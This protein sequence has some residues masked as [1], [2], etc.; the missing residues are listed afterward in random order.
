MYRICFHN[1][2]RHRSKASANVQQCIATTT[3]RYLTSSDNTTTT[4]TGYQSIGSFHS[5]NLET[6]MNQTDDAYTPPNLPFLEKDLKSTITTEFSTHKNQHDGII[7]NSKRNDFMID[8]H[9]WTFLNH[10]AFGG[11]LKVGYIRSEQWRKYIEL[12]PLRYFDRDLLPHLVYS[13]RLLSKFINV[14]H[15]NEIT[16]LVN[17]TAGL[18]ATLSGHV[19]YYGINNVHIILWDTTYGSVKKMAQHYYGNDNISEIPFQQNYLNRIKDYA[20]DPTQLFIEALDECMMKNKNKMNGKKVIFCL[21]HISSNTA[22]TFPIEQLAIQIKT[23]YNYNQYDDA[24]ILVDGA[25]AL[26]TQN[27]NTSDLL[28][29]YGID[30]Y[31]TNLHKWFS[32]PRGIACMIVQSKWHNTILRKPAIISHGIDENDL[33]SRYIWD[34]CRDYTAALSIPTVIN[35]WNSNY[36]NGLD[37]LRNELR[38]KLKEG[39]L[40]LAKHWYP[41]DFTDN[42]STDDEGQMNRLMTTL[43]PFS[44]SSFSSPMCLIALPQVELKT[45]QTSI[46]AKKLQDCL[47]NQHQIEVPIKCIN[48]QLYIRISCHIY[49]TNEDFDKLGK[50]I[51]MI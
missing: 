12:Q 1:L 36:P 35:Y 49:N 40:I 4:N 19:N 2:V 29:R 15:Y 46:T 48:E 27:L 16:L 50:V 24:I 31:I 33:L 44:S 41:N 26:L 28:H 14:R 45:N 42:N 5:E 34:G 39:L 43:V 17:A 3:I 38:Q 7:I 25:H 37:I 32:S 13:T 18:N 8:F 30:I 11:A 47:Y 23:F 20:E 22:I 21:D 10:G 51:A 6:L 9:N